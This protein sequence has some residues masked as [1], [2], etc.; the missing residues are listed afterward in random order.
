[1]V[2]RLDHLLKS[3]PKQT[4][5]SN[6]ASIFMVHIYRKF[7]ACGVKLINYRDEIFLK[8]VILPN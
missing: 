7:F 5:S 2:D 1:M 8:I 3:I 4:W 6:S